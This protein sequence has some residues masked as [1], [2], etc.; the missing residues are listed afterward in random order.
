[1]ELQLKMQSQEFLG[2]SLYLA[3][4]TSF[5]KTYPNGLVVPKTMPNS[6]LRMI[7]SL[8]DWQDQCNRLVSLKVLRKLKMKFFD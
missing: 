4:A 7:V 3:T 1:M 5:V 8:Q 6:N 2:N